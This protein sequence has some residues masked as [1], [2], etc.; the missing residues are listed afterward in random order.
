MFDSNKELWGKC[1]KSVP[2]CRPELIKLPDYRTTIMVICSVLPYSILAKLNTIVCGGGT[3]AYPLS[4]IE[5]YLYYEEHKDEYNKVYHFLK[6]EQSRYVWEN[7][8]MGMLSGNIYFPTLFSSEPYWGNDI[9]SELGSDEEI[10]YA[11][12][13]EGE[14]LDRAIALNSRIVVHGFEPNRKQYMELLE[15]YKFYKNVHIYNYG[16]FNREDTEFINAQ[17][18]SSCIVTNEAGNVNLSRN[19]KIEEVKLQTIDNMIGNRLD[20]IAL[21]IEGSEV[22]ALQGGEQS[23]RRHHPKLAISV[24]HKTAHYLEIPLLI[25]SFSADYRLF[26]RQHSMTPAESV[27]YAI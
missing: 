21:D 17:G 19:A 26:F 23:I 11:G 7:Y 15:K 5:F 4:Q 10:V 20:L 18:Y 12:V 8:W 3:I 2:V 6:D 27:I 9:V 14:S 13:A 22:E 1:V 16:L 24:Y 25:K